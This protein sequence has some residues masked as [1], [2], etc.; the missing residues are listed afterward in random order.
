MSE[1]STRIRPGIKATLA[2]QTLFDLAV[3]FRTL[4]YLQRAAADSSSDRKFSA[5]SCLPL[6]ALFSLR[7]HQRRDPEQADLFTA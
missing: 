1:S 3:T 6:A 7:L 4:Q 2:L 5:T